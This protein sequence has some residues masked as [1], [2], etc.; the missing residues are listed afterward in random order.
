[1]KT[2]LQRLSLGLMGLMLS[3]SMA[4][5]QS[6]MDRARSNYQA[7]VQGQKQVADLTPQERAEVAEIDRIARATK[8]DRRS[9]AER[10]RDEEW[11]RTGGSPS[12]LEQSVIDLK[13]R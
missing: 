8:V 9:S 12:E 1:M 2:G 13:C 4:I 10:C 5:A 3:T 6:Q 7:V 11:K